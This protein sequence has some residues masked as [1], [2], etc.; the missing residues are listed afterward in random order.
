MED[1]ELHNLDHARQVTI[2]IACFFSRLGMW[3]DAEHSVKAKQWGAIP[4][5]FKLVTDQCH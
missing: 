3:L 4:T 2:V 1:D 5:A